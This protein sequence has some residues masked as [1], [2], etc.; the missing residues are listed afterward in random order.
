MKP[1]RRVVPKTCSRARLQDVE[2]RTP[3]FEHLNVPKTGDFG[4]VLLLK[5][6]HSGIGDSLVWKAWITVMPKANWLAVENAKLPEKVHGSIS[7][8]EQ[9][10]LTP[11]IDGG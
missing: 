6:R 9:L 2:S 8:T 7:R 10:E 11:S 4:T 5:V 1:V 3:A